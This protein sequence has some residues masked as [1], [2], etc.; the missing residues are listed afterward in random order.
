MKDPGFVK[1][2]KE[3][4]ECQEKLQA[5]QA[6]QKKAK[7]HF[8]RGHSLAVTAHSTR[9]HSCSVLQSQTHARLYAV[10]SVIDDQDRLSKLLN[11]VAEAERAHTQSGAGSIAPVLPANDEVS[12]HATHS[13]HLHSALV[14]FVR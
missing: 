11:P 10:V 5:L 8:V 4:T 3:V 7:S 9:V 14:E 6:A 12:S 1:A 13:Q 2:E